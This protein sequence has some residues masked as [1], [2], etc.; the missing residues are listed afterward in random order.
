MT[1]VIPFIADG[2]Q[3]DGSALQSK[4]AKLPPVQPS[5]Q[6]TGDQSNSTSITPVAG[7]TT[8]GSL[9]NSTYQGSTDAN[10]QPS[11]S[12]A[13]SSNV[14]DNTPSYLNIQQAPWDDVSDDAD[15]SSQP[16]FSTPPSPFVMDVLPVSL[17]GL[18]DSDLAAMSQFRDKYM[19]MEQIGTGAF[20]IV[21][22]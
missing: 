1:R 4:Y 21:H 13:Y 20:A 19:T 15:A 11:S 7:G 5:S 17:D 10:S 9:N 18:A 2:N 12:S 22:V 8:E 3:S 6:T 14:G 16:H